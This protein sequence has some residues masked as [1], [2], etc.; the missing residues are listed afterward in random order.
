MK[1]TTWK[2]LLDHQQ[3]LISKIQTTLTRLSS[4]NLLDYKNG[5]D[6]LRNAIATY[7][8]ME[9]SYQEAC[10]REAEERLELSEAMAAAAHLAHWQYLRYPNRDDPYESLI[11][12]SL[13]SEEE[14]QGW[15][16]VAEA[17]M[18]QQAATE[19]REG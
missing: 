2:D 7:R 13:L 18:F 19:V 17:V 4:E 6:S 10:Q 15:T 1:S 5:V 16:R 9:D 14:K 8:E 3:E 12:W 11:P